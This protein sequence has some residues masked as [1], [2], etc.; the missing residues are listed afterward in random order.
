MLVLVAILCVVNAL[1][2]VIVVLLSLRMTHITDYGTNGIPKPCFNNTMYTHRNDIAFYCISLP[3]RKDH[4]EIVKKQLQAENI[5]LVWFVGID[6]K[7]LQFE[8]IKP[9]LS[10]RYA[11]F[12]VQNRQ[13]LETQKTTNDYRGHLGCTLSHLSIISKINKMT[14]ILEDDV[15]LVPDFRKRLESNIAAANQ[16][17]PDWHILLLGFCAKYKDHSFCK[18]NDAFPVIDGICKIKYWIGGWGYLIR[19]Q[20]TAHYIFQNF[21]PTLKWHIDISLAEMA[22]EGRLNVLGCIPTLCNH[23]GRLRISSHDFWQVGHQLYR[24]DT[25]L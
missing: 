1:M 15:E 14:V 9:Y 16:H 19:D 17:Y 7:Q 2:F 8:K 3:K 25:N 4:F 5:E 12:F 18:L 22:Q 24:S 10:E 20:K 21:Q 6:G 11:K 23:A 13:D